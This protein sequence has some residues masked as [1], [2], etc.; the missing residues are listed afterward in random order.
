M[1][2]YRKPF[3]APKVETKKKGRKTAEP[4]IVE[5]TIEVVVEDVTESVEPDNIEVEE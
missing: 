5:P 3:P 2:S 1:Y 4:V